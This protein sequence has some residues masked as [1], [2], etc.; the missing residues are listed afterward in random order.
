MLPDGLHQLWLA[1]PAR[2]TARDHGRWIKLLDGVRYL[3]FDGIPRSTAK[4]LKARFPG[5]R[6]RGAKADAWIAAN[7]ENPLRDWVDDDERAGQRACKA[8]A[9]ALK[10]IAA[11]PEKAL[12]AFVEE[13]NAIDERYGIIDTI[14]REEAGDVFMDL[15]RRGGVDDD[16]A[17][18]WFDDWRDF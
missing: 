7:I 15:A 13:L 3:K 2:V 8:Y 5:V 16:T 6:I 4:A 9:K 1:S 17:S 12:R 10:A 11:D 14:R 18:D